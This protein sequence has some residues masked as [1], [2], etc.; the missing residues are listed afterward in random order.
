VAFPARVARFVSVADRNGT[1]LQGLHQDAKR[2][3]VS[4]LKAADR[5]GE[6]CCA[7][8]GQKS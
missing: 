3:V 1:A 8:F 2:A 4:C 6:A 5:G 7:W